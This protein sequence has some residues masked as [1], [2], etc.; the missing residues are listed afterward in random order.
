MIDHLKRKY[1]KYTLNKLH[2]N[3]DSNLF[4]DAK[5]ESVFLPSRCVTEVDRDRSIRE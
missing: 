3:T 4:T 1:E 2:K 5:I